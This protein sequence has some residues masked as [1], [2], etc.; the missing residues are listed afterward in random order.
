MPRKI[1]VTKHGDIVDLKVM[2]IE[3]A[4]HFEK[5]SSADIRRMLTELILIVNECELTGK[6]KLVLNHEELRDFL[7]TIRDSVHKATSIRS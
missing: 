5:H 3:S 6:N 1:K 2:A 4:M 7:E